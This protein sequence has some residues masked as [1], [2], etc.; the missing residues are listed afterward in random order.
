MSKFSAQIDGIDRRKHVK[1][2]RGILSFYSGID[3]YCGG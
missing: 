2:L 1:E 3:W